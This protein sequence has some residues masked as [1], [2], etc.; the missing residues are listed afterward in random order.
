MKKQI[1]AIVL[2]LALTIGAATVA[3]AAYTDGSIDFTS[4][5]IIINE[6]NP[7]DCDCCPICCE[8]D[9]D[10]EEGEEGEEGCDCDCPC[11]CNCEKDYDNFFRKLGVDNNLYFGSHELTVYGTFDSANKP[12]SP[13]FGEERF[14]TDDGKFTGVE[15]IN[16]NAETAK[17][18]ISISEFKDNGGVGTTTLAGAV[19]TLMSEDA[20]T[21]GDG[22]P[23]SQGT[24][25][26]L[27]P[28][29]T[30]PILSVDSG[31]EVKAAWYGIL[32]TE[33]GT[34]TLGKAQAVMTWEDTT[35]TP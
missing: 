28:G 30:K 10:C 34:S 25:V 15:V 22:D 32:A 27:A 29:V 33:P 31:R 4:G 17:I 3:L 16:K 23:Y 26:E 35:G 18:S 1:L 8:C 2:A 7:D 5:S 20:I 19:L 14:T 11:E 21:R 12:G 13:I 24:V 6:P 9:G